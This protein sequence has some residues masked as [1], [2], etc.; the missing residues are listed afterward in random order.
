[1]EHKV[2]TTPVTPEPKRKPEQ[3]VPDLDEQRDRARRD[4]AGDQPDDAVPSPDPAPDPV[5]EP[6]DVPARPGKRA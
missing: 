6:P 1:M 4:D 3:D 2:S 5:G